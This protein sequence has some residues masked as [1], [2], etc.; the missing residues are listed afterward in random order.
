VRGVE[1]SGD[2]G[3]GA[4]P[5]LAH[6]GIPEVPFHPTL[7]VRDDH[8]P[9]TTAIVRSAATDSEITVVQDGV[10]TSKMAASASTRSRRSGEN[11][12]ASRYAAM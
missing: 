12:S 8:N 5:D 3:A 7:R 1:N 10:P 2:S 11:S 6:A 4:G 9:V